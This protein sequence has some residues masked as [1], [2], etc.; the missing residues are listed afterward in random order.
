MGTSKEDFFRQTYTYFS[1]HFEQIIDE[2]D[3]L[4]VLD[5]LRTFEDGY[6]L[7]QRPRKFV[8]KG[9]NERKLITKWIKKE[10]KSLA[11]E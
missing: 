5:I 4:E 10:I 8:Y 2:M 7:T 1:V 6:N 9:K 11:Q 3:H